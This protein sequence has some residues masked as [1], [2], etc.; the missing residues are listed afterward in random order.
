MYNI[1]FLSIY[2]KITTRKLAQYINI[3]D[4]YENCITTKD[5]SCIND[6]CFPLSQ[7]IRSNIIGYVCWSK[8]QN[9]LSDKVKDSE[10]LLEELKIEYKRLL[11]EIITKKYESN[12]NFNSNREY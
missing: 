1:I 3:N 12:H 2:K 8:V 4:F 5:C 7:R 11:E 6:L 10:T 9:Y